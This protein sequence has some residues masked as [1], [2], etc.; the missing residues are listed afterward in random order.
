MRLASAG[1]IAERGVEIIART[2][3]FT[4]HQAY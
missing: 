3:D 4:L 2:L 1:A